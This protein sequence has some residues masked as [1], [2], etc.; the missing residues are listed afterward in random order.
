MRIPKKY[1]YCK[2]CILQDTRPNLKINSNGIWIR[3]KSENNI[4]II[5]SQSLEGELLI[6]VSIYKFDK[7][8]SLIKRIEGSTADIS[9][10]PWVIQKGFE[11]DYMNEGKRKEFQRRQKKE[12]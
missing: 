12:D 2:I 4:N 10:N 6:N 3:E 9:A 7:R 1:K 8:N 5:K 11:I